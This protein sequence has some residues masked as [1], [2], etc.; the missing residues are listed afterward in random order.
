MADALRRP[1][2]PRGR[3]VPR[4]AGAGGAGLGRPIRWH[5]FVPGPGRRLAAAAGL[6][7]L[8]RPGLPVPDPFR[9]RQGAG[10]GQGREPGGDARE[11]AVVQ[12]HPR[13]DEAA[14]AS[15]AR[16][17]ASPRPRC[18]PSPKRRRRSATPARSSTAAWPATSWTWRW[19]SPP[20][21]SAMAR[22]R[23]AS[24][25]APGAAG[26]RAIPT[27]AGSILCASPDYQ[28]MARAAA[29]RHRRAGREPWR[30]GP[31][32]PLSAHLRGG[33][34][35]GAAVLAAGLDA[36]D[37]AEDPRRHVRRRGQQRRR[38]PAGEA[39]GHE[40]IGATLQLYDHGAATSRKGAC[41][42]G[43]DIHDAR[44][45]ADRLGIPHYVL[46]REARFR[47]AVMQRLRRQLRPRR[48]AHPLRPL[49]PDREVPGP[50]RRSPAT[51]AARRWPPATTPGASRGPAGAELHRAAD[52]A[53]DQ[54]YFLFATTA[55]PARLRPLPARRH[56]RQ[57]GGAAEA[58]RLG[59][60]VAEK[61]DSQDIC[62]VPEGRYPTLVAKLRP[63]AAE[64][65]RDRR[66]GR[67]RARPHAGLARYTVGQGRGLGLASREA[68]GALCRRA[69][70]GPPPRGGR[71][72]RRAAAGRR[73]RS[74]R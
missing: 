69:R 43:Q 55:R 23:C 3:A 7:P 38:R 9:P 12:R 63:D 73:S 11:G 33:G 29:A 59:L 61:P 36:A 46:D 67:P 24:M 5:P 15:T 57:G 28:A 44:H 21:P 2:R 34:A 60:A 42:A 13:R 14:P 47:D 52:P 70:A 20:A 30:R 62:F 54:S 22:W 72:P 16:N 25:A 8:P 27:R 58:A 4:A 35:A 41:C 37:A 19:R 64:A 68:S 6:P 32:R 17:G 51:S 74:P 1:L 45:V 31:L 40:V 66:R 49:Q 18:A 56:A 39:E 53:R 48:D 26:A 71:P 65:G 50:G 10:G